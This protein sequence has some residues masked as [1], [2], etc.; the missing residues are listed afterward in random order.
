MNRETKR[1][2]QRQGQLGPDGT[3][4]A[5]SRERAISAAR[6]AAAEK[7]DRPSLPRRVG[8]YLREVRNELVKV[9]WPGRT[10][11]IKY[12]IVVF[13]TIVVLTAI[14]FGLDALFA[15]AVLVLFGK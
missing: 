13:F 14:V 3:P 6:V 12:T 2:L 4:A 9:A 11:V 15:K 8:E 5:P 10:E 1:L 7:A